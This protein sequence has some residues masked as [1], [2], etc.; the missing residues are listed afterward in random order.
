VSE[1][2]E[3]V[4][5][6]GPAEARRLTNECKAD[7][8][9]LR[10]KL[11]LLYEGEAHI[12]LGYA[13]WGAY[14]ESEFESSWRAGYRELE[15]ARVSRAIDPWDNGPVPERQAR[16][17]A[18]LLRREDEEAVVDLWADLRDEFGDQVTAE[19]VRTAVE[20][21]LRPKPTAL[22]AVTDPV[23]V[24]Q[25]AQA[26]RTLSAAYTKAAELILEWLEDRPEEDPEAVCRQIAPLGWQGL[27]MRVE[28]RQNPGAKA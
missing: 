20:R 13:S 15:A 21:K 23:E 14:W 1:Q 19:K 28:Q 7:I 5:T 16:E 27:V 17:L 10:E 9:A 25:L 3:L 12:A 6:F 8:A 22:Q 18:R 26:K 2:R 11:L 24:D 4:P